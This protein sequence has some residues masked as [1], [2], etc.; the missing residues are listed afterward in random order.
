M[1]ENDVRTFKEVAKLISRYN[2]NPQ[3]VLKKIR[4]KTGKNK[5]KVIDILEKKSEQDLLSIKDNNISE[6]SIEIKNVVDEN[7]VEELN[8]TKEAK[9]MEDVKEKSEINYDVKSVNSSKNKT[10]KSLINTDI[11]KKKIK[12]KKIK[13]KI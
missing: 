3:E 1:N 7:S 11:R 12:F 8:D 4:D 6:K 10:F 2:E 5:D 9:P 13:I